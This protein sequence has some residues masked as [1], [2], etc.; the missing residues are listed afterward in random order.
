MG[1]YKE[2]VGPNRD[3]KNKTYRLDNRSHRKEDT[4]NDPNRVDFTTKAERAD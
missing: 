1:R 2:T 3:R 4:G